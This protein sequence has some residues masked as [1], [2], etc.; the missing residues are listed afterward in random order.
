MSGRHA[1]WTASAL[2]ASRLVRIDD[3]G[4]RVG[5]KPARWSLFC[6]SIVDSFVVL[7]ARSEMGRQH[8]LDLLP[9]RSR[10]LT[11]E[12]QPD[13]VRSNN[14]RSLD[15]VERRHCA[16]A[17]DVANVQR[18]R[19][20]HQ[21]V[22]PHRRMSKCATRPQVDKMGHTE[23]KKDGLGARGGYMVGDGGEEETERNEVER[24]WGAVD[25]TT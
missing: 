2:Q 18:A 21:Q 19:Q 16:G 15:P 9:A 22:D 6:R 24:D 5:E 17:G 3:E 14:Y 1:C 8:V 25:Q 23:N 11:A 10:C 20:V 13:R 12:A 4:M 7:P